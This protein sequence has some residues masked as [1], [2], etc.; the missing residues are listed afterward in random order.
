VAELVTRRQGLPCLRRLESTFTEFFRPAW[1]STQRSTD[2]RGEFVYRQYRETG[3]YVGYRAA[4]RAAFY[5][6]SATGTIVVY[7]TIESWV[8][9]L[10]AP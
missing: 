6:D 8:K 7:G 5:F 1:R 4:D 3:K 9:Q 2:E 10:S